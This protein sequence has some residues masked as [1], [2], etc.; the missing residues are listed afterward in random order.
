LTE[1][2]VTYLSAALLFGAYITWLM[3]DEHQE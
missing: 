1:V 2:L 3:S